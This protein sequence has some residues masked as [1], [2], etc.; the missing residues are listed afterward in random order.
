MNNFPRVSLLSC[1]FCALAFLLFADEVLTLSPSELIRKYQAYDGKRIVV[2]GDVASGPEMTVMYLGRSSAEDD[3]NGMLILVPE[4]VSR[5][6]SK[7][8]KRFN[9][10]LKKTGR[11]HAVLQGTFTGSAER[12]WGHQLCC[13][14]KLQVDKVIS[15]R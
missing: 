10:S 9:Q 1:L 8:E 14:F 6:P 12:Q 3:P 13:R 4:S 15:I 2:E 5:H 11:A 7:V